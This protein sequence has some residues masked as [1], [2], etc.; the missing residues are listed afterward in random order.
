MDWTG[1][2]MREYRLPAVPGRE[3]IQTQDDVHDHS[4]IKKSRGSI[5]R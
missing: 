4:M 1:L 3:E 2:Y 5:S